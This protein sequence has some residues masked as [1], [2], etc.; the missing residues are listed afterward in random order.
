MRYL[1][2]R[3][4]WAAIIGLV[5]AFGTLMVTLDEAKANTSFRQGLTNYSL[6]TSKVVNG[7]CSMT[8]GTGTILL[9]G[10]ESTVPF[11]GGW[12]D[13]DFANVEVWITTQPTT[14]GITTP[15]LMKTGAYTAGTVVGSYVIGGPNLSSK[16]NAIIFDTNINGVCDWQGMESCT[17]SSALAGTAEYQTDYAYYSSYTHNRLA[18]QNNLY[19]VYTILPISGKYKISVESSVTTPY[20]EL[21]FFYQYL[22]G[23]VIKRKYLKQTTYAKGALVDSTTATPI[24]SK[25]KIVAGRIVMPGTVAKVAGR[26]YYVKVDYSLDGVP[27]SGYDIEIPQFP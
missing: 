23:G 14:P 18:G 21:Y 16:Y 17:W 27:N 25:T 26:V 9:N 20:C 8:Y 13:L 6:A 3:K 12:S 2:N 22:D 19:G 1:T 15:V 24:V 4:L 10:S 11:R 5:T 7:T